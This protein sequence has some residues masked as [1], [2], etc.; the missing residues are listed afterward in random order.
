MLTEFESKKLLKLYGIPTV[1][2]RVAVSEED[3]YTPPADVKQYTDGVDA[4]LV[5]GAVANEENLEFI[6]KMLMSG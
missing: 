6:R 5:E 1:E 2:T 3:V 4:V